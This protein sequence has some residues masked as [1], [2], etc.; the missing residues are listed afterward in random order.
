MEIIW[1]D[2]EFKISDFFTVKDALF[3]PS[4]GIYH[5]PSEQE[6][7]EILKTAKFMD[8]VRVILGLPILVHCWMRP[9]KVVCEGSPY[10]G[11]DY[12]AFVKGSKASNHIKGLAVDWHL[13]GFESSEKCQE[14]R[15]K[16]IPL[17]EKLN[18]RMED[19]V[20][21]WIHL[22]RDKVKSKRFFK[23]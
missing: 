5:T 19:R 12:N 7:E 1:T 3:L 18:L 11:K 14:V 6:K 2:P 16:L 15:E 22:D 17:L 21:P 10:N 4:W 20:G 8:E 23:P 9:S 13:N